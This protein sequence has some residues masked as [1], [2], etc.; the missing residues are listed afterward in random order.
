MSSLSFSTFA[1]NIDEIM[2]N[3]LINADSKNMVIVD[4]RTPKEYQEDY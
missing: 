4:V 1:T 3:A 2:P